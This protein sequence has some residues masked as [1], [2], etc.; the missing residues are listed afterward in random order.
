MKLFYSDTP[1]KLR[2]VFPRRKKKEPP[3]VEEAPRTIEER[4]CEIINRSTSQ[5]VLPERTQ[6]YYNANTNSRS[7]IV[8]DRF[9]RIQRCTAPDELFRTESEAV[10]RLKF[11]MAMEEMRR[12]EDRH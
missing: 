8:E 1:G 10:N 5:V 2:L 12:L 7:F 3:K 11:L 9:G 4:C 6:F